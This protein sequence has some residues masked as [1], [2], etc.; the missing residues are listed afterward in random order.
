MKLNTNHIKNRVF[1]YSLER[2]NI[3]FY[4][5]K[6]KNPKSRKADWLREYKDSIS[7]NIIDE[8]NKENWKFWECYWVEQLK[9]WGFDLINK[10]KGGGGLE[11]HSDEVIELI[12]KQKIGKK[13]NRTKV[14]KDKGTKRIKKP[15]IKIGSP[16]GWKMSKEV[17]KTK[18]QKQIGK[19]K[20]TIETKIKFADPTVYKFYNIE[21]QE[22]FEGIRY[23]FQNRY[24]LKYKG[25]YNLIK[26]KAKTYKKWK[27]N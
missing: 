10:N 22:I 18:N 11:K 24:N 3:P 15:G 27:I 13:Q 17:R 8:V 23:D 1:I 16:K 14:R 12:R 7:F 9:G 21:T 5:G 25:I 6:T 2:N 19:S 26:G 4:I 20:H